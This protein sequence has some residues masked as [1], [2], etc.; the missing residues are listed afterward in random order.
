MPLTP[1]QPARRRNTKIAGIMGKRTYTALDMY[2]GR[3]S[4]GRRGR[5]ES[6]QG[7]RT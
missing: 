2:I 1:F 4:N 3:W 6:V 5:E 7:K